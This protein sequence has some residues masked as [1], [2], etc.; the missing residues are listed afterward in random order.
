[1]RHPIAAARRQRGFTLVELVITIV[2]MG[3]L[4]AVGSSMISDSFTTA[5]MVNASQ[6][7]ADEARYAVER[8]A[9]EIREVQYTSSTKRYNIS[10]TLS[11]AATAMT[12]TR[13]IG[14]TDVT[15][16]IAKSGSALT[17][18]YSSPAATSNLSTQVTGFSLDFL[19]AD[20]TA[21]TLTTA[22]RFVV[23]TL[24]VTDATSGQAIK[25]QTRVALRNA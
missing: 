5:R 24:T 25:Q 3:I 19:Q 1:M 15:V 22:V 8:L 10:S 2:I 21:T 12:F 14:G 16:T 11:P 20:N 6:S 13:T 4:A 17:L 18:G 23:I 7:S 9:R